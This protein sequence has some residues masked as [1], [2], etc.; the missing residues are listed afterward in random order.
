M[1]N[2]VYKL[3]GLGEQCKMKKS[4]IPL[5]ES[6]LIAFLLTIS[7]G[8]LDAYTYI[9]RGGTFA[10]AQTGNI[11]LTGVNIAKH[12][13]TGAILHFVPVIAF[14]TGILFYNYLKNNFHIKGILDWHA[15]IL[16][17][18][19]IALVIISFVPAEKQ[20]NNIVNI[21]I[22]F[23]TSLQYGAFQKLY[24]V[25]YAT[26]MCSG[27]L[28]TVATMLYKNVSAEEKDVEEFK[29]C[30]RV[31]AVIVTFCFGCGMGAVLSFLGAKSVWVCI[32]LM[33]IAA[34]LLIIEEKTTNGDDNFGEMI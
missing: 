14:F 22:S 20:Y 19:I 25:T 31:F 27:M 30:M 16:I 2:L 4:N 1:I 7:G 8:F 13:W 3:I 18:E 23:I 32:V 15:F 9:L 11:V 28:R 5:A 33:S 12:N 6:F 17:L 21:T 24:G 29:K 26:T 10:N 34:V